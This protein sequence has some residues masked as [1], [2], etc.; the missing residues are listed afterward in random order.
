[1]H[2]VTPET[3]YQSIA[4]ARPPSSI[5]PPPW[6]AGSVSWA[7]HV[8]PVL[9]RYCAKCHTGDGKG[10]QKVDMTP[11]PGSLGFDETYW[12]FTGRPAWG[13]PYRLPKNP[14]P[15]FGIADMIMVEGYD[16]RDPAGYATPPPMT[17]LSYRSRLIALAAS[18]KH[19][20]VKVAPDDLLRLVLWVDT[21][22]PYRGSEEV[23]AI[24]DPEFQGI[25][26]LSIR[27]RIKTAPHIVRPGPLD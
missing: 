15:G 21:M 9:D 22:C 17:K 19:H 20:D 6:G 11:R 25:D 23:R 8:R 1:M 7:R 2:S 10:R 18:G 26:W 13:R 24:D 14:P 12:L 3:G 27:P 16:Q 4:V 5:T